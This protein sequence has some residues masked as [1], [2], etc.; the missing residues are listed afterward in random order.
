MGAGAAQ[1]ESPDRTAVV[2]M[3]EER[4]RRPELVESERAVED[5]AADEAEVALQV[6]GRKGAVADDARAEFASVVHDDLS[7]ENFPDGGVAFDLYPQPCGFL[8]HRLRNRAHAADRMAPRATLAVY[9]A[10][11]MVQKHVC[12]VGVIRTRVV[13]DHR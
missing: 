2:R 6:G 11:D 1:V 12:R 10:E 9:L 8:R 13:A 7:C 5:V 4:P 3:A